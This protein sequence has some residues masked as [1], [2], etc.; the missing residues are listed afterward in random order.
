MVL[1]CYPR[2]HWPDHDRSVSSLFAPTNLQSLT[3]CPRL[4]INLESLCFHALTKCPICKPFVLITIRN[5]RG[6][7]GSYSAGAKVILELPTLWRKQR[8]TPLPLSARTAFFLQPRSWASGS[9]NL[10]T[11][12]PSNLQTPLS[13]PTNLRSLVSDNSF[14]CHTSRISLITPLFATDPK[15]RSHKPFVCHTCETPQGVATVPK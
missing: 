11:F 6:G 3:N 14:R 8:E 2:E 9:P 5:A 10:P 4:F 1:S 15:T 13:S 7:G 12:K